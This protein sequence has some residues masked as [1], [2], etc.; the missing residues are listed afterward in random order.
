MTTPFR[1]IY[2]GGCDI[3]WDDAKVNSSDTV[4][5]ANDA[6]AFSLYASDLD[7][8]DENGAVITGANAVS[9]TYVSESNGKFVG[10]LAASVSLTRDAFYWLEVTATPDGGSP[11][12]RR[13]LV[14]AV[15]RDFN[16]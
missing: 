11:H 10:H 8:N 4:F 5:D 14:Q 15:D 2:L 12:T 1:K 13:A 7:T 9:M 16:K 6:V 3:E